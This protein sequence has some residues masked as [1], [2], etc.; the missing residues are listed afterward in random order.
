MKCFDQDRHGRL[1][2]DGLGQQTEERM[3]M[4]VNQMLMVSLME[5]EI[6]WSVGVF[7]IETI[8]FNSVL[9][10]DTEIQFTVQLPLLSFN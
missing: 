3:V 5:I 10:G 6:V 4:I 2:Q 1:V 8:S 7:S 9:F